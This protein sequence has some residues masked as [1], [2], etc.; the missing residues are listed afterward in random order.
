[1]ANPEPMDVV[2]VALPSELSDRLRNYASLDERTVSQVLRRLIR[3]FL[4]GEMIHN[5]D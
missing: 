4:D 1:M 3:R 2:H 5:D